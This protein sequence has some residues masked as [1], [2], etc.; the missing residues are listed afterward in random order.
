MK[1]ATWIGG[2]ALVTGVTLAAL[3]AGAAVGD[4]I[5]VRWSGAEK[6][7]D[8]GEKQNLSAAILSVRPEADLAVVQEYY[9]SRDTANDDIWCEAEYDK[10][11]TPIE[12]ADLMLLGIMINPSEISDEDVTIR[13]RTPKIKLDASQKAL[14]KTFVEDAFSTVDIDTMIDFYARRN[15]A[16]VV[17]R[18]AYVD[19]LSPADFA[20]QSMN[21]NIVRAVG[22][23]E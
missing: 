19:T 1:I 12:F 17:G 20:T 21:G 9:C 6:T 7:L 3:L 23:V 18:S 15:G 14:H 8:T 10:I 4:I 13:R 16:D 11:V 2:I 5:C 22:K